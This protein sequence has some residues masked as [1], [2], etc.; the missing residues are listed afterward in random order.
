CRT[1]RRLRSASARRRPSASLA[2]PLGTTPRT[3]SRRAAWGPPGRRAPRA[4]GRAPP[5]PCGGRSTA[6][7]AATAHPPTPNRTCTR[8]RR[9]HTQCAPRKSR[10]TGRRSRGRRRRRRRRGRR[11]GTQRGRVRPPPPPRPL[12]PRCAA[13]G[14]APE[15]AAA[16]ATAAASATAVTARRAGARPNTMAA[17]V[18]RGRLP[19]ASGR[20]GGGWRTAAAPVGTRR[21]AVRPDVSADVDARAWAAA[22]DDAGCTRRGSPTPLPPLSAAP[23]RTRGRRP[24]PPRPSL[25]GGA[26]AAPFGPRAEAEWLVR[27]WYV[28]RRSRNEPPPS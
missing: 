1:G 27:R 23:L 15:R 12:P 17:G 21:L 24:P 7:T 9:G 14:A 20:Q 18:G 22:T 5:R 25:S 10:A 11:R 4:Q 6:C 26:G 19:I 28:D 3:C 8:P 16:T 2:P 13:V